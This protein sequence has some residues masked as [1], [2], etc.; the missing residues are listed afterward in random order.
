MDGDNAEVH[1]QDEKEGETWARVEMEY[2]WVDSWRENYFI[3]WANCQMMPR[4][5]MLFFLN[6]SGESAL[7]KELNAYVKCFYKYCNSTVKSK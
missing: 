2:G 3:N 7:A 1:G 5:E 6:W 4:N